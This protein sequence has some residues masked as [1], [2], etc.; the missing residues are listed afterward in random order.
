M[1]R[2]NE[3]TRP[4]ILGIRALSSP[5]CWDWKC[6]HILHEMGELCL[7]S[8]LWK[9]FGLSGE[10]TFMPNQIRMMLLS[11][12]TRAHIQQGTFSK[13][14]QEV[15][16]IIC[17][18]ENLQFFLRKRRLIQLQIL[19]IDHIMDT[20][21]RRKV[22][23]VCVVIH[24]L[25]DCIGPIKQ[26]FSFLV[27]LSLALKHCLASCNQMRSPIWNVAGMWWRSWIVLYLSWEAA[28]VEA[29]WECTFVSFWTKNAAI[30]CSFCWCGLAIGER[31]TGELHMERRAHTQNGQKP[32]DAFTE[33]L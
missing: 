19:D 28:K 25:Q 10:L 13:W 9:P 23:T 5:P 16:N 31:V 20:Q 14:W 29:T 24:M 15:C 22:Q 12:G 18:R 32:M 17:R 30:C 7:K 11:G 2:L 1:D 33:W 3:A 6:P 27:V 21:L 8:C 26:R 4:T